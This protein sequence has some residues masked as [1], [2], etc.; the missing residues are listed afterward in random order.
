MLLQ[1]SNDI[2]L[3]ICLRRSFT[4]SQLICSNYFCSI[5]ALLFNFKQNPMHLFWSICNFDFNLLS[6]LGYQAE[7]A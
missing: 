4:G 6:K 2:E 5:S 7:N 3:I 1:N